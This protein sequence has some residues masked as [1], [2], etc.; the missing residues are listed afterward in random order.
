MGSGY[1]RSGAGKAPVPQGE[2]HFASP[3]TDLFGPRAL[4]G[5]LLELS[6]A[7]ESRLTFRQ[8]GHFLEFRKEPGFKAMAWEPSG[9]QDRTQGLFLGPFVLSVWRE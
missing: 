4:P 8:G 1:V 9:L 6:M 5:M 2:E 3:D 7:P